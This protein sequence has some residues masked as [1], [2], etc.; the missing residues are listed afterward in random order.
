MIDING[1]TN[2]GTYFIMP[3]SDVKTAET[4]QLIR[5]VNKEGDVEDEEIRRAFISDKLKGM[6]LNFNLD[7]TKDAIFEMVIDKVSNSYLKGSGTGN[8]QIELDTKDKFDMYGDFVIDNGIYDFKYGG[9]INKPFTVKRG[10]TISW[11][12]DPLTAEMNIEAIYRVSANPRTLLENINTTRKIPIDLITR[13]SGELFDSDI[14]FDIE[15]P[16][17]SSTVASELEFKLSNNKTTQFV[18]LLVTGSFYNEAE[19]SFDSNALLYSTG[20]DMITNAFDN[21][22]NNPDS[23]FKIKPEYT[24]GDR[25]N[26]DN[27]EIN[28]QLAIGMDYQIN[29]RI[30][31]NGKVGVPIGAKEQANV[32]GEVNIE[33]LMNE[34]GTLR[35]SV[36]NRQNDIQYTE[37]EEGYTQG[38]GLTYQIDFEN[39]KEL[40]EKLA[41]KKKTVTDSIKEDSVLDSIKNQK[42]INFKNKKEQQNE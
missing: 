25:R 6:S 22:L 26:I 14:Q 30:I 29:D 1:R 11:N 3:L 37:Q 34:A 15:I 41:L 8:L 16:N 42:L 20:A 23:R 31:I 19:S 24:V 28:D 18:A 13:I 33:F 5:F 17:S 40:L 27:I 2:K 10:G 21:L 4:S 35:S 38:V 12:G 9:I 7:V 32:I 36:F 39:G